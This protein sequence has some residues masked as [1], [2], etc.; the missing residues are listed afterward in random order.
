MKSYGRFAMMIVTSTVIMFGLM[1]LN[2]YAL[3]H[4]FFSETRLY[5]ALLMG[6]TMAMIM[7]AFMWKMYANK[8]LNVGILGVS[9]IIFALSLY[10]VR[11]QATIEDT[12]W[13]KAMIPHQSIAILT[14]ERAKISD[15]R[16]KDLADKIIEAQKKE[17]EEMKVLIE[18]LEQR[19]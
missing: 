5:M 1:Y 3:D 10:L 14:S 4:V 18:E 7:M 9:V 2:T 13:M 19:E 8:K 17:I 16:V 12:S 11:S 15:S 6:A